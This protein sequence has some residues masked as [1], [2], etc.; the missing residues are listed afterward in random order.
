ME[1]N[2]ECDLRQ[3]PAN[4]NVRATNSLW[5]TILGHCQIINRPGVARAV[6]QTPPSLIKSESESSISS[7]YSKQHTTQTIRAMEFFSI[8]FTTWHIFEVFWFEDCVLCSFF[9]F[10]INQSTLHGLYKTFIHMGDFTEGRKWP[11]LNWR[12]FVLLWSL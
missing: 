5:W 4:T 2:R 10:L 6:L 1:G 7:K 12:I 8:V 3:L 11:L 9:F